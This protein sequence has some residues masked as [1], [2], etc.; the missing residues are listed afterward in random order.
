MTNKRGD[1]RIYDT[2]PEMTDDVHLYGS[3]FVYDH[4]RGFPCVVVGD[5]RSQIRT[6]ARLPYNWIF[7]E[8][9]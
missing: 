7:C 8:F 4:P 3:A 9:R 6:S 1:G 5:D 2:S